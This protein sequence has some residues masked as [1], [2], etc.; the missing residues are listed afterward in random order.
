MGA[1]GLWDGMMLSSICRI[2]STHI[3]QSP[4]LAKLM[5][6]T[7]YT[8]QFLH[9][10]TGCMPLKVVLHTSRRGIRQCA[11]FPLLPA[12]CRSH[13]ARTA[14]TDLCACCCVSGWVGVVSVLLMLVAWHFLQELEEDPEM[15]SKVALYKDSAHRPA[16]AQDMDAMT[17]GVDEDD[18]PEIPLEELLDDMN[19]LQLEENALERHSD[20]DESM[21]G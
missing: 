10:Q 12:I 15:R 4:I 11:L 9:H 20:E 16:P 6:V 5:G 8:V 7:L 14:G 18:L 21:D 3:G 1:C 19:A 17:E 13:C 2:G